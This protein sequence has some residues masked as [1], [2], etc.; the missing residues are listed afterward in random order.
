[1]YDYALHTDLYQINM[2]KTY[3]K[4]GIHERKAIFDVYFRKLPFGN[5]Y[6][7]F[8]GLERIIQYLRDFH[9]NEEDLAYLKELGY[10]ED[11]LDF[12]KELRFTGHVWSVREGDIVFNNEPILRIEGPLVQCQLIETALLNIVNF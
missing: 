6:G 1:M 5:G 7:V 4:Q 9:F 12:L 11:F 3:W 8:A 2:A 10:K